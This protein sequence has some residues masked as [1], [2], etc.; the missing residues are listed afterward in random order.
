M[1]RYIYCLSFGLIETGLTAASLKQ[2]AATTSYGVTRE[3]AER[4]GKL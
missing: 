3:T 4:Q 1:N 2:H